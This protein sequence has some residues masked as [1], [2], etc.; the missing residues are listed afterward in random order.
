MPNPAV[1]IDR[2]LNRA[3]RVG[4]SG[5]W[6]WGLRK[7][8][9]GYG[10]ITLS[11]DG[12]P[13]GELAHRVAYTEWCGPIPVGLEVDHLCGVR[14]C[15]RPDHLEAVTGAVNKARRSAVYELGALNASK[16]HCP[17]GHPYDAANTYV[18]P[19]SGFRNCRTCRSGK[20]L[21]TARRKAS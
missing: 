5:C 7:D 2:R 1:P 11:R 9:D 17:E 16:T 15:I 3:V 20:Y 21:E 12:R 18:A 10:R 4:E 14:D 19:S 13:R 6:H 8:R